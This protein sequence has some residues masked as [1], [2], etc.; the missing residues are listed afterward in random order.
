MFN[1]LFPRPFRTVLVGVWVFGLV[2][3]VF[4]TSGC[5]SRH[6]AGIAPSTLPLPSAH[7]ILGPVEA[8][9]CKWAVLLI[10][11]SGKSTTDEIIEQLVQGKGATAL[12]AVTVEH[13]VSQYLFV[14]SDC[15]IVKGLAVKEVRS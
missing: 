13:K 6:P 10:P 4:S 2:L 14:G 7:T 15:T 12:I 9:S 3:L 1:S 8:S 11:V 5:I